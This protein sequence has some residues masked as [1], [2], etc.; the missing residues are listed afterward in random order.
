MKPGENRFAYTG[1]LLL[2]VVPEGGG[3]AVTGPNHNALGAILKARGHLLSL[4][5]V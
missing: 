1:E 3:D 5:L 2:A 4:D